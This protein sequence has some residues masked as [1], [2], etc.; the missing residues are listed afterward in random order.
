MS[1]EVCRSLPLLTQRITWQCFLKPICL[2]F[3]WCI[4]LLDV[5]I[6][7]HICVLVTFL[8][9]VYFSICKDGTRQLECHSPSWD[10]VVCIRL[11]M[12]CSVLYFFWHNTQYKTVILDAR[13]HYP[14]GLFTLMASQEFR[15]HFDSVTL[16]GAVGYILMKFPLP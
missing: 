5:I 10:E 12:W 3:F 6:L 7:M 16:K 15:Y 4:T 14:G 9:D 11:V 2:T 1:V 13:S 8:L